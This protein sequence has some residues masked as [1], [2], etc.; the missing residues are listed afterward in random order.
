MTLSPKFA[1]SVVEALIQFV[2]GPSSRPTLEFTH[3][4]LSHADVVH[5]LSDTKQW[6]YDDDSAQTAL[7]KRLPSLILVNLP[8][9]TD[10]TPSIIMYYPIRLHSQQTSTYQ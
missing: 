2:R 7:V 5:D 6:G 8:V 4:E 10:K 3:D 9:N 1:N